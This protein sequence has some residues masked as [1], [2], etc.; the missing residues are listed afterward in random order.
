MTDELS[1]E[2]AL[3]LNSALVGSD[4]LQHAIESGQVTTLDDVFQAVA[5]RSDAIEQQLA[6]AGL[7]VQP[8][9]RRWRLVFEKRKHW[10]LLRRD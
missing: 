4:E 3:Q 6:A 2:Q 8:R 5:S 10:Q 1:K 7:P 9:N